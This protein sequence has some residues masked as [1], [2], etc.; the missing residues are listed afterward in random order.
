MLPPATP[1]FKSSTSQPGLFTSKERITI[2]RGSDVKSL[3]GIGIFSLSPSNRHNTSALGFS[4]AEIG[5][6]GAPSATVPK[7]EMQTLSF[8]LLCILINC[9][10][11][12]HIANTTVTIV[13][14]ACINNR[15]LK[16][17][18]REILSFLLRIKD[19][20]FSVE[21]YNIYVKHRV[22]AITI[23]LKDSHITLK[24][25][26]GVLSERSSK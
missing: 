12:P 4:C 6:I 5:T 22:S 26:L 9:R 23:Q 10:Q 19:S 14:L 16:L 13:S 24:P 11:G 25:S 21:L 7:Y 15:Y 17:V 3:V 2:N 8:V 1:P 20:S 18:S